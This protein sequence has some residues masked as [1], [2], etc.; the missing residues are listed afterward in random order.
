MCQGGILA[1]TGGNRRWWTPGQRD[2]R[3]L[4][5]RGTWT[6]KVVEDT[7]RGVEGCTDFVKTDL[8][9][10]VPQVIQWPRGT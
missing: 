5:G 4:R 1:V 9:N 3:S 6:P 8:R 7:H 2:Y 10:R